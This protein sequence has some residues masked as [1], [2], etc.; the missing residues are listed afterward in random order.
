L[1]NLTGPDTPSEIAQNACDLIG[2]S[3]GFEVTDGGHHGDGPELSH[4]GVQELGQFLALI[5]RQ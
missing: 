1:R 2:I 3:S 4:G 5:I